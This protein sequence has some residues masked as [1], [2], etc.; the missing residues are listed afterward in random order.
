MP[1]ATQRRSLLIRD[2]HTLVP[3]DAR[4]T[5]LHG[6]CLYI[7]DSALLLQRLAHGA[8]ALSVR[9]ALH[10]ATVEGRCLGRDDIGSLEPG[11]RA[12]V[13]LFDLREIGY[14]GAG[15]AVSALLLCAPARVTTLLVEGREVVEG[16]ELRTLSLDRI[17]ARHRRLAARLVGRGSGVD[18]LFSASS[19]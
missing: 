5:V 4:N 11:K 10:M 18:H 16:G 1:A 17:L 2:I 3:M 8:S 15:D 9:D 19:K 12:D 7:E 13:A 14:S 6:P